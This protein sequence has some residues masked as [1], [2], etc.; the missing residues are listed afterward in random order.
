MAKKY[1][2]GGVAVIVRG[3][4]VIRVPLSTLPQV[5]EGAWAAGG[6]DTRYK[7]TNIDEFAADLVGELN[8]EEEDG[9]TRIHQMFDK[10]IDEAIGQGAFGIEEHEDQEGP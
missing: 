2:N 8:R 6:I 1:P 3:S 9:T 10:A 5:L 4:I 7:I